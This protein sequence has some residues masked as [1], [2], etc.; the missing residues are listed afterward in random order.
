MTLLRKLT[1]L[2][3]SF[4]TIEGKNEQINKGK[5]DTPYINGQLTSEQ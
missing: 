3:S 4:G 2:C 5:K 1:K